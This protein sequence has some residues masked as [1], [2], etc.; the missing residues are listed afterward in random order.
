[1]VIKIGI[2]G[3]GKLGRSIFFEVQKRKDMEIVLIND[4]LDLNFL[5]F[6]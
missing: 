3:F 1:M 2:N 5:F 4:L 6:F